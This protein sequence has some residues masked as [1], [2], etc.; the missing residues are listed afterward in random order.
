MASLVSCFMV[1]E[2]SLLF[3]DAFLKVETQEWPLLDFHRLDKFMMVESV[4]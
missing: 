1:A 2:H 4:Y 3:V